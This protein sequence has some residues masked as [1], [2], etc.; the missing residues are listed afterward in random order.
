MNTPRQPTRLEI[1]RLVD[2]INAN[3]KDLGPANAG[4]FYRNDTT[5][6]VFE[7]FFD[8]IQEVGGNL[9]LVAHFDVLN[10]VLSIEAWRDFGVNL[11]EQIDPKSIRLLPD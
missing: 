6:T 2:S 1:D 11:L 9:L 4:M 5:V 3:E 7:G 10:R 8:R